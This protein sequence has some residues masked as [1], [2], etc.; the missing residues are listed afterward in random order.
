MWAAAIL[1]L[2]F[3]FAPDFVT[4]G[5]KALEDRKYQE[6]AD[7][8]AKAVAA[9][10][11]DY[12]A[13]FHLA[14]SYS[15]L[16]KAAEAI[17]VYKKVLELKPN[18][19]EAEL[20]LGILLI[21]QKQAK[22]AIPYL[23]NAT[24]QKP[25]EFRPRNYLAKALLESGDFAKAEENYK[26]AAEL[27]P[28]SA[29]AQLGLAQAQAR[30]N[31]LPEAAEHFQKAAALDPAYKDSLLE[32]AAL[33]ETAKQSADAIAIYQQF[34][35]NTAAQ[36]RLG[37]LLIET[38]RY[39]EAIERLEKVIQ[40]DPTPANSLALAH[41]YRLNKE[42]EKALPLL[43]KAVAGDPNNYDLRMIYGTSLRDQK[44]FSA[45]AREFYMVTQKR[46]DS[47]EAW[48]ELIG[49]LVALDDYPQALAALDRVKALGGETPGHYF[50]RAIILDKT[51]QLK[52]ALESYQK[53]LASADGKYPDQEFQARQRVRIIQ[54]ELSKR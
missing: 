53:F 46:P 2:L 42:P 17:P 29:A 41:A 4:E 23:Q 54:K 16:G 34:P 50:F 47:K 25:K 27:D 26:S 39:P 31:R 12:A 18:L 49:M 6:A 36:E 8:F 38:K 15:L 3:L 22:D 45:A 19:Y 5:M 44:K 51:K 14:L 48:N 1:S 37:E 52:P 24:D 28:K 35:E 43:E 7:L 32:L 30:Q 13:N 20:N 33:L 40:K 21:G 10:P 9:D 11:A